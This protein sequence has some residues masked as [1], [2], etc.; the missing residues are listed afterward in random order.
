MNYTRKPTP[1]QPPSGRTLPPLQEPGPNHNFLL[2]LLSVLFTE[3]T[4]LQILKKYIAL[5]P[6]FAFLDLKP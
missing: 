1:L 4:S 3:I 5:S 2:P 6:K